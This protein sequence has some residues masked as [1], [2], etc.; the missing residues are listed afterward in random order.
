MLFQSVEFLILLL[1]AIV[2]V[3]LIAAKRR[4]FMLLALLSYV[5]YG[6]WDVR[7]LFLI[8]LTTTIDFSA[9]L[10]MHGVVFPWKRRLKLAG[11]IG[12]GALVFLGLNWPLLQ[13]ETGVPFSVEAF[14]HPA[15]E[16]VWAAVGL[17]VVFAVAA[18]VVY[19][20][21]VKL[22]EARRRKA[23]VA[24]SIVSNLSILAFFKYYGFFTTSMLGFGKMLGFEP[25]LPMLH[26]VLPVGISFYTFQSMSYVIDVYRRHIQPE[27]AFLNYAFFVAYFPQLVAGPILRPQEFLPALERRWTLVASNIISGLHL[28]LNGF[29][30]KVLVAD[31]LARLVELILGDPEGLSSLAIMIGAALFAIQIYCDFSGYS[32]IARGVSRM[33]GVNIAINF[34]FPYFS[35]SIIDF[36]RTWHISLSSWLRDYLYIPL[37]GGRGSV[38]RVYFNLMAT[39]VLGGLWH[40]AAWN[41][42][43]WGFY[44][45]LLLCLNRVLRAG[46]ERAPLLGA[47]LQTRVGTA[48]RWAGTMYFVL[49]GWLIFRVSDPA[50]P[51][52]FSR[53]GYCMKKYVLFDG[54][55]SLAA[56]GLGR[57]APFLAMIIAGSFVVVHAYSRFRGRIHDQLD[58]APRWFLPPFYV[59][60]AVLFFYFWPAT[61]AAFIYFQF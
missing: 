21:L 17:G 27:R 58:R 48:V 32:D 20:V 7:F 16:G 31:N 39:M 1:V 4:Q 37:G 33:F 52:D 57:G 55:L 14:L 5:F 41:F 43:I 53:L 28:C 25:S 13:K 8:L 15:W 49:L 46:I 35:T 54:N 18:P 59:A 2:G 24:C 61:N 23:F 38:P 22:P 30:K 11:I 47:L 12:V 34:N 36:W 3:A 26:V 42:V 51:W 50:N 40:G 56:A 6:W 19:G 9:A 10:G 29:V 60:M 44:Q 45:G